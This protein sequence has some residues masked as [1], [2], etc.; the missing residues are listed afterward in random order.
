MSERTSR[1]PLA[2]LYLRDAR[3][4]PWLI[5]LTGAFVLALAVADIAATKFVVIAGVVTPAGSILFSLIFVV[6]DALHR[7][8]GARYVR[9]TILIAAA[10][11]LL[12]AAFFLWLTRLPAPDFFLFTEWDAI[13]ALAPG[14]VIGSVV[15]ATISQLV[16][17]SAYQW[18]WNRGNPLWWRTIGSNLISLPIDSVIFTL[19]AFVLLPPLFG[20]QPIDLATAAVRVAS[21]QTVFKL[22]VILV[23]TPL[24]YLVPTRGAD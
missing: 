9:Q 22:V 19:L 11:N 12:M 23:M 16:N 14:I 1:V 10:L 6:R 15:A 17:T 21:G 8:A 13:F 3:L 20:A 5:A 7:L 24:V 18:L 2:G 4:I